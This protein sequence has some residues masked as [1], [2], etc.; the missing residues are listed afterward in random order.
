MAFSNSNYEFENKVR[1]GAI[2]INS[3]NG[4][5]WANQFISTFSRTSAIRSY[6]GP[7]TPAVDILNNN[8]RNYMS[9]GTD[10]FSNNNQVKNDIFTI[11]NNFKYYKGKHALTFGAT[12][13]Y[14]LVGNMFMPGSHGHYV[15]N[16]LDDFINDRAPAFYSYLFSVIPG[17]SAVFA[18]ELK[19]GQ[20]AA[21]I[22]DDIAV[23]DRLKLT[24][25]LRA[26]LPIYPDQPLENPNITTLSFPDANGKAT[27]YS[28]GAWPKSTPLWSP[29]VGFRWDVNGDKSMIIRGGTGIFTGR[30]PFVWL[31]NMPSNSYMYQQGSAITSSSIL[32]NIR[33]STNIDAHKSLFNNPAGSLPNNANIVMIDPNFKFPQVWRTNFAVDKRLQN[34]WSVTFEAIVTKDINAVRMR[35]ANEKAPNTFLSGPDNRP[36]YNPVDNNTRRIHNNLSSAIILENT[37]KGGGIV[38]TAQLNKTLS[39]GFSASASYTYTGAWDITSNPGAQATS[40]WNSNPTITSQNA[41]ELAM[42]G[43]VVPHRFMAWV[44][45]RKEYL[46]HLATSITIFYEARNQGNLSYTVNGDLNG[47]GNNA[48]DLMY[49]PKD[50]SEMNFLPITGATPFTVQQQKDAFDAF[51]NNSPYLS[52]RRGMYAERNSALQPWIHTINLNFQQDLFTNI[53]K[54]KNTLRLQADILNFANMLNKDWGHRFIPTVLRNNPLVYVNTTNGTPAYNWTVVNGQLV[55]NPFQLNRTLA[56]TWSAQLG[57]RY[58]F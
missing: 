3:S 42:S 21:Y 20:G 5:K 38:L 34:G 56:S 35:N 55:T 19:V 31:T 11:T 50:Q 24:V 12:Y 37:N 45:Y 10:P 4:G 40:V 28:T 57:I 39:K 14:Q 2:E 18:A 16:S 9:F 43:F 46:K 32:A 47:D 8:A 53:G 7:T 36:A 25:G 6:D 44:S 17:K 26:D 52:K 48:G 54:R 23:N 15:H 58:I 27:N 22:Q 51:I 30:I 49:I 13:D 1:S 41:Q 29:R 33:Y